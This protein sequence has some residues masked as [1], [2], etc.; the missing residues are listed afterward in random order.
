VTVLHEVDQGCI[1]RQG[2]RHLLGGG[3]TQVPKA[4]V[5]LAGASQF[6]LQLL[7]AGLK[8]VESLQPVGL[9]GGVGGLLLV[10]PGET[11]AG[12]AESVQGR[13]QVG[14][15]AGGAFLGLTGRQGAFPGQ[16]GLV[17]RAGGEAG[18]GGHR[19]VVIHG[20]ALLSQEAKPL[21][22]ALDRE[23]AVEQGPRN[24][25]RLAEEGGGLFRLTHVL[26]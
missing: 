4:T 12:L 8:R 24:R 21:A 9:L 20:A 15:A 10:E 11:G 22:V 13:E 1:R 2:G 16:H 5:G 17:E 26:E 23:A 18:V 19:Q 14:A 7:L 6:D 25:Q 3:L